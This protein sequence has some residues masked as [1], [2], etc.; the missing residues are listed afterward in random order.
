ML[1]TVVAP[2]CGG[3]VGSSGEALA[4]PKNRTTITA[5]G[6]WSQAGRGPGQCP[7][8]TASRGVCFWQTSHSTSLSSCGFPLSTCP[9]WLPPPPPQG[10]LRA[11]MEPPLM[12]LVRVVGWEA[13][14]SPY[15]I[16]WELRM[17][18]PPSRP[19]HIEPGCPEMLHAPRQETRTWYPSSVQALPLL[20]A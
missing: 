6:L 4:L 17:G 8:K 7:V 15:P 3:W 13:S 19:F 20:P 16:A 1:G 2:T 18:L 12:L 5:G 9:C 14:E 11:R 10:H